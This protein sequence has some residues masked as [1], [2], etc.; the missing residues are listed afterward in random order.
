MAFRTDADEIGDV[1][2]IA[3]NLLTIRRYWDGQAMREELKDSLSF[4]K[5]RFEDLESDFDHLLES[6]QHEDEV[7][8]RELFRQAWNRLHL[9]LKRSHCTTY[10]EALRILKER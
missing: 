10:T 3:E 5:K 1:S 2:L 9:A 6:L 7:D 4:L 8:W